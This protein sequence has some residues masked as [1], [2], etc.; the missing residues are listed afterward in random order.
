[1]S[2]TGHTAFSQTAPHYPL[3]TTWHRRLQEGLAGWR[4]RPPAPCPAPNTGWRPWQPASHTEGGSAPQRTIGRKHLQGVAPARTSHARFPPHPPGSA[5]R[6]RHSASF[7]RRGQQDSSWLGTQRP[8]IRAKTKRSG[9][10]MSA[11]PCFSVRP[12]TGHLTAS[13]SISEEQGARQVCG[14]LFCN[15]GSQGPRAPDPIQCVLEEAHMDT[16]LR[17]LPGLLVQASKPISACSLG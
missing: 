4:S 14:P 5:A 10:Q 7:P 6:A 2:H 16:E 8:K 3:T 1:M 11:R 15:P 12:Q 9:G 13:I 17:D